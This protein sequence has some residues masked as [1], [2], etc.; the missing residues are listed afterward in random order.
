LFKRASV[1]SCL[2]YRDFRVYAFEYG[3]S[4]IESVHRVIFLFF[5]VQVLIQNEPKGDI[6]TSIFRVCFIPCLV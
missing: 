3:C 4:V 6:E 5:I 2:V 1:V